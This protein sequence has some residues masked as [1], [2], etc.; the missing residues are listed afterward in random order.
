MSLISKSIIANLHVF[1]VVKDILYVTVYYPLGP[2][3]SKPNI[4]PLLRSLSTQYCRFCFAAWVKV[5]GTSKPAVG[6][7]GTVHV[8]SDAMTKDRMENR[9]FQD[10]D[11]F[12]E[13]Y[14]LGLKR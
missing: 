9:V 14:C 13:K 12:E 2:L 10:R 11:A 5:P 7:A 3:E 1:R 6:E 4:G 8:V